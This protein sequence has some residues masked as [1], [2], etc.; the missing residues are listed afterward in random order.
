MHTHAHARARAGIHTHVY[1]G[2]RVKDWKPS[3]A[4]I[5]CH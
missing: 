3:R 1:S 2:G 4:F 5:D